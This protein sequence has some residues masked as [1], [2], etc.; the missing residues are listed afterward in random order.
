ME[1]LHLALAFFG[2]ALLARALGG[3]DLRAK[4]AIAFDQTV[5]TDNLVMRGLDARIH[6][7]L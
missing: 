6:L 7:L 1:A 3:P 4:P 5:H 2:E